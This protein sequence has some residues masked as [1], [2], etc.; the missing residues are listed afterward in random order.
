MH[1]PL[2]TQPMMTTE[3]ESETARRMFEAA[4]LFWESLKMEQKNQT[5]IPSLK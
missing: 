5:G 4:T 2:S 3:A 1:I